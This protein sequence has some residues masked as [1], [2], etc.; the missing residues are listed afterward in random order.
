MDHGHFEKSV[1]Q[2]V[3]FDYLMYHPRHTAFGE[4]P[5]ILFL[6]GAGERGDDIELVKQH[7]PLKEISEDA[8]F[9]AIIVAPQ[10]PKGEWWNIEALYHFLEGICQQYAINRNKIYAT[11]LSMGGYACWRMA[12]RYPELFAAIAPVCGGGDPESAHKLTHLPIWTFHG[13]KDDLVPLSETRKMVDAVKKN[14]KFRQNN[15][16]F[17]IYSET[18]HD[19]WSETYA[20]PELYRWILRQ[21]KTI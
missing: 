11:G 17:T 5:L 15:I 6:H 16:L 21:K 4:L 3:D 9:P 10:C 13:A 14:N 20:N 12:C 19:S 7:G 18:G 8:D 2:Q 1:T